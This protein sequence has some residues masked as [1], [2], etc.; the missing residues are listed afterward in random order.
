MNRTR[1][2]NSGSPFFSHSQRL[3]KF[4]ALCSEIFPKERNVLP[5]T[6]KLIDVLKPHE[7]SL[8]A[9][10][11]LLQSSRE[12]NI[13]YWKREFSKKTLLKNFKAEGSQYMWKIKHKNWSCLYSI[14]KSIYVCIYKKSMFDGGGLERMFFKEIW[15]VKPN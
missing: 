9:L 7:E 13:F 1:K 2:V 6:V 3:T 12:R 4:S 10:T 5:P 11:L 15:S 8:L 14:Y